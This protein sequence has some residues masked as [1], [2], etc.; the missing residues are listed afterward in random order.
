MLNKTI[1]LST[2]LYFAA[3]TAV[4]APVSAQD[5]ATVRRD[6]TTVLALKG[7][8]CGEIVDLK[9]QGENDYLVTCQDGHRY[10]IFVDAQDRVIVED[11]N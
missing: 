3:L 4:P 1:P 11:R 6:L 8:P 9:R 2:L 7:K 10:R 5:D